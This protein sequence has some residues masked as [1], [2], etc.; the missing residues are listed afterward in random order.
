MTWKRY[1]IEPNAWYP[2]CC[3][4]LWS[5]GIAARG[6]EVRVRNA[7]YGPFAHHSK[8]GDRG[9][10]GRSLALALQR[11]AI[12]SVN[13]FV[14]VRK[15]GKLVRADHVIDTGERQVTRAQEH[16][17]Q[18][19]IRRI[20]AIGPYHG[21]RHGEPRGFVRLERL[22]RIGVRRQGIRQRAGVENGLSRTVRS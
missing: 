16:F 2:P 6:G 17:T 8:R 13:A 21:G 7:S 20:G 22:G 1:S 15:R 11:F 3:C 18:N 5:T 10:S 9:H 19:R 4:Q 14:A 12:V